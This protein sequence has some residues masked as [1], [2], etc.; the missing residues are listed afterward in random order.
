MEW[1]FGGIKKNKKFAFYFFSDSPEIR[2]SGSVN[3]EIKILWPYLPFEE[4]LALY[5]NNLAFPLPK[6]D[7]YQ[8]WLKLVCWFWR[9]RFLKIFIVFLLFCDYLPLERGNPLHLKNLESPPPKD[10]LCQ[11]WLKLAQWLWTRSRKCK[12]LQTDGQKDAGQRAIRKAH[13]SFQ[14]RWAKTI[15]R[16]SFDK[17]A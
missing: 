8:L 16:H 3:Q 11:V 1:C 5:L 14:L 6:D 10:D 15:C 4:D 17:G 13:L 2:V 7:L 12:S 9:R